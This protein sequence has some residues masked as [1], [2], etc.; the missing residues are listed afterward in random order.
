MG[1]ERVTTAIGRIDRALARIESLAPRPG[2]APHPAD[3]GRAAALEAANR[4]LRSKVEGAI[5]QIDRLL[6]G[7]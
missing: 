6:E 3:D 7:G 5:A 1:D 2:S 4:A